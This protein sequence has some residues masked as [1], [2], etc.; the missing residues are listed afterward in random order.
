MSAME[1]TT[2]SQSPASVP[3]R[4]SAAATGRTEK[5]YGNRNF[6]PAKMPGLVGPNFLIPQSVTKFFRKLL[7]RTGTHA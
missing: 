7:Q 6:E 1:P 3:T 4:A 2:T 5:A